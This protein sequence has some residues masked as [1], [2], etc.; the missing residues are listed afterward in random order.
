MKS[1]LLLC[2]LGALSISSLA[3][4]ANPDGEAKKDVSV[5]GPQIEVARATME[6]A[7]QLVKN[8][9]V[10]GAEIALTTLNLTKPDTAEWNIET[11]QALMQT[12]EQIAREGQPQNVPALGNRALQLLVQ[13]ETKTNN[14]ATRA[15]AKTLAGFIQERYLADPQGAVASYE[16]AAQL[17]PEKSQRAKEAAERLRRTDDKLKEKV[18]PGGK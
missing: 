13:L 9:D 2:G 12:A 18:A 5:P 1:L 7:K 3:Q 11:A 10:S 4:T 8:G 17:A 16:A 6:T 14:P 15:A